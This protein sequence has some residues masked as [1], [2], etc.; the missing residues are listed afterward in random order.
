VCPYSAVFLHQPKN[1]ATERLH[2]RPGKKSPSGTSKTHGFT[3]FVRSHFMRPAGTI[4]TRRE[5]LPPVAPFV[6]GRELHSP[7][8]PFTSGREFLAATTDS[9]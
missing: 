7:V 9:R 4:C 5:F 8:A 2:L 3:F 6:F 1:V